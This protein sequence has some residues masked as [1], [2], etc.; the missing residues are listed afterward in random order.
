MRVAVLIRTV[1]APVA[2]SASG[3]NEKK[4][5]LKPP[6]IMGLLVVAAGN[7]QQGRVPICVVVIKA[8]IA[9]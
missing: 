1:K 3:R 4:N 8:I 9:T 7:T 6:P 2:Y 5:S